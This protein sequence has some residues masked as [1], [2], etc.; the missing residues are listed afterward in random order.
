MAGGK[1][2]TWRSMAEEMVDELGKRL[3]R[4][5]GVQ[6]GRPCITASWAL[7]GGEIEDWHLY[8]AGRVQE[9]AEVFTPELIKHLVGAHGTEYDDVL[10]LV[11][12]DAGL[13]APLA[14]GLAYIRAEVI[15]AL[16]REMALT[17]EDVL[18]RRT[19][20]FSQARDGGLGVAAQVASMMAR[21]L[22]WSPDEQA[23]Q[24]EHY[25]QVV[26]DSRRWRK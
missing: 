25:R 3:A 24:V 7:P 16:R 2:T 23:A 17:V 21:E 5:H 15:H 4:R 12:G 11:E 8:L 13:G 18:N 10:A 14:D 1:L 26:E 19:H 22:G 6:P 20:V 9:H